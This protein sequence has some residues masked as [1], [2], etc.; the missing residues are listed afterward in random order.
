MK[1]QCVVVPVDFSDNTEA[2]VRAALAFVDS[3]SQVNV[4]H[5]LFAL[6][7]VSPGVVFG[8]VS[9]ESRTENINEHFDKLKLALDTPELG[10][11]VRIGNPGVQITDYANELGADLI[12]IPSHGYHGFKRMI[13]GSVAERVI[14]LAACDVYVLRRNDAE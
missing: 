13:L 5:V 14:R 11:E 6:D 2:A 10:T 9:D 3:P 12:V 1:K 4:V 8:G 7:A